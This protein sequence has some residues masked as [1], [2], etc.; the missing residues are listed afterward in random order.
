MDPRLAEEDPLPESV[1]TTLRQRKW[2]VPKVEYR[3]ATRKEQV[4]SASD[5]KERLS[6]IVSVDKVHSFKYDNPFYGDSKLQA[7]VQRQTMFHPLS[8]YFQDRVDSALF[9][10]QEGANLSELVVVEGG[11]NEVDENLEA[12]YKNRFEKSSEKRE[13]FRASLDIHLGFRATSD[14]AKFPVLQAD[15]SIF[16]PQS[17]LWTRHRYEFTGIN[18]TDGW[19]TSLLDIIYPRSSAVVTAFHFLFYSPESPLYGK[20]ISLDV[21]DFTTYQKNQALRNDFFNFVRNSCD[22]VVSLNV[23]D[24]HSVTPKN[25]LVCES[26][27]KTA[28]YIIDPFLM[29]A[30]SF[31]FSKGR[32]MVDKTVFDVVFEAEKKEGKCCYVCGKATGLKGCSRCKK[33]KYCGRECQT[34]DWPFH[35][36]TCVPK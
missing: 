13:E 35:R 31:S 30:M 14:T 29:G 25:E 34:R 26:I 36:D 23:Y 18:Y 17:E 1:K 22:S 16:D 21:W 15:I 10:P 5:L 27:P 3:A 24:A 20:K 9:I 7:V 2:T 4:N 12:K 19:P 28:L 8:I 6:L 32:P 11:V 33:V